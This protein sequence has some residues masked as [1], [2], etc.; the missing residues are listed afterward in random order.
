MEP[1]SDQFWSRSPMPSEEVRV[2]SVGKGQI[3]ANHDEN[4]DEVKQ[5]VE[6]VVI[7]N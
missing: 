3:E 2:D 4:D 1:K 7:D 6:K 5:M